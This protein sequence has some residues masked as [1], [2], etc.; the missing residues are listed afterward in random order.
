VAIHSKIKWIATAKRLAMPE[1]KTYT[2]FLSGITIA[3]K[4][5]YKQ[6]NGIFKTLQI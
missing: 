1:N 5:K 6:E 4:A 3:A 2:L